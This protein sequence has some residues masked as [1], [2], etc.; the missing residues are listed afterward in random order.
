MTSSRVA[1]ACEQLPVQEFVLRS[2]QDLSP[3][4][5]RVARAQDLTH[6]GDK[7]TIAPLVIKPLQEL[8]PKLIFGSSPTVPRVDRLVGHEQQACEQFDRKV[9]PVL[10]IAQSERNRE[11]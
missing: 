8:D 4:G 2:L 7:F 5:E 10:P 1:L 6:P 3:N 9:I 11:C